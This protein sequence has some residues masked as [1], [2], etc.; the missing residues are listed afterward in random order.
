MKD[1]ENAVIEHYEGSDLLNRILLGLRDS[2]VDIDA[3]QPEDLAP[4]EEFHI[5]GRK[6]TEYLVDKLALR[7]Q[8]RVLDVG[9]GIGGATRYIA[10]RIGCEVTGIDLTPEFIEAANALSRRVGLTD[11]VR[12]ETAS[13]LAMPFDEAGFD[14]AVTVHVA[15]NIRDR[16]TLYS[17]IARVMKPGGRL[18]LFD[19]MKKNADDLVFPVPWAQT[20][21]TSHLTTAQ[22]T[23]DLLSAA[24]FVV[25]E[26]EDRTDFAL[27]FFAENQA[28]QANGPSPVGP[29][30]MM[31][32]TAREKL[33]NVVHNIQNDR[34][35]PVQII[36]TRSQELVSDHCCPINIMPEP[37]AAEE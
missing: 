12:F 9:C 23:A 21:D 28:R 2:G 3:L 32:E 7:P 30:L 4:V 31:G 15:M 26:I 29:H 17:E 10:A 13:A 6:A 8:D 19:V 1:I 25:S 22:E 27:E 36:A 11:R 16:V 18:G 24:G 5:G 20:P 14:A 33:M 34:I 35:A 37:V